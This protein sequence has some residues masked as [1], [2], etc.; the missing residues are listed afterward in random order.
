MSEAAALVLAEITDAACDADGLVRATGRST[1][2]V[3]AAL[4]E[5][6]LAALVTEAEGLFRINPGTIRAARAPA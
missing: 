5:L 6:E 3:A 4:V 2:E 1:G